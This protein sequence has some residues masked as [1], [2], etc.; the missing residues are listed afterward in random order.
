MKYDWDNVHKT[1]LELF[2]DPNQDFTDPFL[3]LGKDGVGNRRDGKD[4]KFGSFICQT[5]GTCHFDG[6]DYDGCWAEWEEEEMEG[7]L[8]E[9]SNTFHVLGDDDETWYTFSFITARRRKGRAGPRRKGRRGRKGSGKGKGK[10]GQK[11]GAKKMGKRK[12]RFT[13]RHP[14][15]RRRSNYVDGFYV[16]D[17]GA[18]ADT[19]TDDEALEESYWGK[20]KG[21][22]KGKSK[23]KGKKK[24]PGKGKKPFKGKP[25]FSPPPPWSGKGYPGGEGLVFPKGNDFPGGKGLSLIH[26]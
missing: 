3:P 10:L 12:G 25:G 16:D 18:S 11:H 8:E 23:G 9:S 6:E 24:G 22:S 17:D 26:I 21:K 13:R 4:R 15:R 5:P 19:S 14:K 20:G 2:C 1:V 7:F